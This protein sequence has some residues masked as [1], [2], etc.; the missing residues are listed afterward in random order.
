MYINHEDR[1]E[2]TTYCTCC[3][4]HAVRIHELWP[5]LP[6]NFNSDRDRST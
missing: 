6:R 2:I 3:A 1:D 5:Q 4:G